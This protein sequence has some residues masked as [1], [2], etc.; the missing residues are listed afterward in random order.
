MRISD[1][2]EWAVHVCGV[3]AAAPE[4][5]G[6]PGAKLAE[7]HA[8]PPAYLAKHLQA[9]SRAGIVAA[10][11]G[12]KGG[13]RLGRPPAK[14]SLLDIVVAI[15]GPQPAFRCTE[16]RKQGPCPAPPSACRKACPIA[17][18]FLAAEMAWRQALANVTVAQ[19]NAAAAAESFDDK[20]RR[21]FQAWLSA[22]LQ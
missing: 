11:R 14:I 20:R 17:R 21:D 3:L 5:R 2:V 12:A 4:G 6:V 1:G 10:D 16:I 15:E 7:F 13:Y 8:L 19:M 9:L 18:A 22:A